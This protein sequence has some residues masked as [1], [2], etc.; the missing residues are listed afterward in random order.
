MVEALQV[1]ILLPLL[2]A[3]IPTNSGMFCEEL[4]AIAAFDV[5][6]TGEYWEE[7]LDLL[8]KDPINDKFETIGYESIYFLNN[9]G[10]F[11][12]VLL[13]NFIPFL[14][15]ILLGPFQNCSSWLYQKREKLGHKIFWSGWITL[16][17]ES[18][19]TVALCVMIG[20]TRNFEFKSWGQI[21]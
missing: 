12:L 7:L 1:I 10:S 19:M 9:M 16:I 8:P 17:M 3:P 11:A 21:F 18:F 20:L 6:E 14:L 5:I 13:V 2:S 15:W 4:T